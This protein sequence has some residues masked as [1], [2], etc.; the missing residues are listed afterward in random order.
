[1]TNP[2]ETVRDD[3]SEQTPAEKP[4]PDADSRPDS[5]V[6]E[7]AG[8]DQDEDPGA[9]P[10]LEDAPQAIAADSEPEPEKSP[11]PASPLPPRAD[12]EPAPRSGGGFF[13]TMLGGLVAAGLGAGAVFYLF[14]E[15]WKP[16]ATD[17]AA[18]VRAEDQ[19]Q[20]LKDQAARIASLGDQVASLQQTQ[21]GSEPVTA[22]IAALS[23]ELGARMSAVEEIASSARAAAE[24]LA[25]R[26]DG[27]EA[28]MVSLEQRPP[29]SAAAPPEL[30]SFGREIAD[31]RRMVEEQRAASSATQ[32][33]IAAA[34]Q[35]TEERLAAAR[36]EADQIAAAAEETAR[37][38]KGRAALTYLQASL[39]SGASLAPALADL[40][41]A[42]VTVPADLSASADAVPSLADLQSAFPDAARAGLS[43]SLRVQ[44]GDGT[45]DRFAAF[46]KAQTGARSLT[47]QQGGDAN[48]VLS[49]AEAAVRAGDV[50][51]ALAELQGLPPEGQ[52]AMAGWM[53]LAQK[54]LA[55]LTAAATIGQALE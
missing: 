38:A 46:L 6:Y 5:P 47:P 21:G 32:A 36:A 40:A 10:A 42:G 9:E 43:A 22:G 3:E 27:V 45:L 16:A 31:L 20:A 30:D 44:Q 18:Q 41:A 37:K 13:P 35:A 12:P 24:A 33:D 49:R 26:I 53:A 25:Q 19:A 34:A 50:P 48:A 23:D 2:S 7:D 8:A 52:Q 15:G 39:E 54:R 28:R 29:E 4:L 14:P 55:A 1:M 11:E 17:P 51:A